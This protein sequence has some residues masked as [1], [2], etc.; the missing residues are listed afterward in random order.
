MWH[1][2]N[3]LVNFTM[4]MS[5]SLRQS[6]DQFENFKLILKTNGWFHQ[7]AYS[8]LLCAQIPKV[9]KDSQVIS[10]FLRFWDLLV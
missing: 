6:I 1:E 9:Q 4:V 8:K 7:H 2:S 10:V 5:K 3:Y